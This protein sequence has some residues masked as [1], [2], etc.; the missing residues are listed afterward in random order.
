MA[1]IR[2]PKVRWFRATDIPRW[3]PPQFKYKPEKEPSQFDK[4]SDV[5]NDNLEKA[6][7]A[8]KPFQRVMEDGLFKV[9]FKKRLLMPTYWLGPAFD[10]VRGTWF[11]KSNKKPLAESIAAELEELWE[12]GKEGEFPLKDGRKVKFSVEDDK[13][14][15]A[16]ESPRW[17]DKFTSST[18]TE[19]YVRGFQEGD[20]FASVRSAIAP[21]VQ[22]LFDSGTADKEESEPT[23]KAKQT[24]ND[25]S[26][27]EIDHLVFCVHGVGQKLGFRLDFVTFVKDAGYLRKGL[28]D[29][30]EKDEQ[31]QEVI[32]STTN[33][34]VQTLP[35]LWRQEFEFRA[36]KVNKDLKGLQPETVFYRDNVIADVVLDFVMY[37]IPE[38]QKR[39][40]KLNIDI[41]NRMYKDFC[42]THPGFKEKGKVS[43][44]AHSLGSMIA[45]DLLRMDPSPLDFEVENTFLLGCPV[46]IC[47]LLKG[48]G[49]PKKGFHSNT[50]YNIM[51]PSDPVASRLEPLIYKPAANVTPERLIGAE[52]TVLE[53]IKGSI[54]AAFSYTNKLAAN[55]NSLWGAI[56]SQL[57]EDKTDPENEK[58]LESAPSDLCREVLKHFKEYNRHQRLD[59]SIPED[60][61]ISLAI[62][63]AGHMTYLESPELAGFILREIYRI[64]DEK[65]RPVMET[66]VER[67]V[68][69][70]D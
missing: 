45:A 52:D 4:F 7:H 70:K 40:L 60:I 36:D 58:D 64:G 49:F 15:A 53:S 30:L 62:G 27:R 26:P 56:T 23:P 69:E 59:F 61:E 8:N 20:M 65:P 9:D 17:F 31:A 3:K 19:T 41:M 1:K 29:A 47:N 37:F 21:T 16:L 51:R 18:S 42:D 43:I 22:Q 48:E 13:V 67:Y 66:K 34:K 10:V 6:F 28:S 46:A 32:G 68:E 2:P 33:T 12:S 44:V 63:L 11:Q 5:D 50:I 14:Q 35:V 55:V 24:K 25:G 57:A 54:D 39:I 38:L